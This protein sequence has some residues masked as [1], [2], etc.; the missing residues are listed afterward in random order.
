MLLLYIWLTFSIQMLGIMLVSI[1]L[2]FNILI[3]YITG[4]AMKCGE[5]DVS[6]VLGVV[7]SVL[8][9]TIAYILPGYLQ[10][11][12]FKKYVPNVQVIF[13]QHMCEYMTF[14]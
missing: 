7:G 14:F 4:I 9:C 1:W 3:I 5:E 10:L 6:L 13:E 11:A 8:G 12:Y 2:T